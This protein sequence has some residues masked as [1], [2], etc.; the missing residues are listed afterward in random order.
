MTRSA[1]I[2]ALFA[3]I[4][5]LLAGGCSA[6]GPTYVDTGASYTKSTVDPVYARADIS[7]FAQVSAADPSKLRHEALTA[8]RARG[9]SAAS[10]AELVTKTLPADTRGVP[11]YVEWANFEGRK[12]LIIVEAI[13]P[14]TGKLTT[15]RLWVLT[16]D[17]TVLFAG[18]R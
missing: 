11:V 7:K 13:G 8:L 4:A 18:S 16:E 6:K 17:G 15:K 10:A 12:A 14:L 9:G 3:M 5:C 2:F 1:R